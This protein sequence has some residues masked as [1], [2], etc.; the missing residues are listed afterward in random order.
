MKVVPLRQHPGADLLRA[1][2]TWMGEQVEQ[3]LHAR[4]RHER[5]GEDHKKGDP[6]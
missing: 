2:E 1:L 3:A 5:H 6:S 4:A